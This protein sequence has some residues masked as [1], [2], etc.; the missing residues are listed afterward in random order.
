MYKNTI[1]SLINRI[2]EERTKVKDNITQNFSVAE[3]TFFTEIDFDFAKEEKVPE[4]P[5]QTQANFDFLS[6]FKEQQSD[7][8]LLQPTQQVQSQQAPQPVQPPA[9]PQPVSVGGFDFGG[10]QTTYTPPTAAYNPPTQPQP[11]KYEPPKFPQTTVTPL[12]D[13][14]FNSLDF[15]GQPSNSNNQWKQP[16]PSYTTPTYNAPM[17][18]P[19]PQ[20]KQATIQEAA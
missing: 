6:S 10:L 11:F 18:R 20:K 4:R 9:R 19:S 1:V 8:S 12:N 5:Q 2:Q 13:G 17:S 16:E 7:I 14:G 15:L 3:G